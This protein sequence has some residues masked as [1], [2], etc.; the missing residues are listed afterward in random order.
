MKT[1]FLFSFVI[2]LFFYQYTVAQ[3]FSDIRAGLTGVAESS[4]GWMDT[5]RDGDLDVI[6]SGEFYQGDKRSIALK[7]YLNLRNDRFSLKATTLPDFYRGDFDTADYNLDGINDIVIVGEKN[8]GKRFASVYKGLGNGNFQLSSVRLE[9]VRDGSVSF[10]DYDAD[11]DAD[12]LITGEADNG[13][14]SLLYRNDRNEKFSLVKTDLDGVRRG[15]GIWFDYNID[16]LPDIILTGINAGGQAFT[17]LY[18]NSDQGFVAVA[19]DFVSLKNSSI[20]VGDV[21]QDGD[22]DVLLLGELQSGKIT[23]RLYRNDRGNG[24]SQVLSPFVAVRSGFADWGDMDHDG[25]LDL[26]ISGEGS[27]GPVSRI[28][29]NDRSGGFVDINADLIPLYMSDGEWGDYNQDGN[30]DLIISGMAVDYSN[31]TRIYRNNGVIKEAPAF[32]AEEPSENIWNNQTVVPERDEPIYYYVYSSTYSDLFDVGKKE[33][34]AFVSPV[35]KP[36]VQ[37]E[38]EEKFNQLIIK[39]YPAWPKIDQGNIVA[40]G[41]ATKAAADASRARVKSEYT[42]NGFKVIE[43]NW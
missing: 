21:D 29:C 5:D 11:G 28:Y 30:L 27:D 35:K 19:N 1:R 18:E 33:Y 10:A 25:D 12:L 38:M 41:F 7:T 31:Y 32:I 34:V 37:Y 2:G 24:F 16:G 43:I 9:A 8:D 40:I 3:S 15:R 20:A 42:A 23:T 39:A 17:A 36:K 22:P 13:P 26:L 14:V 6:A 4:S